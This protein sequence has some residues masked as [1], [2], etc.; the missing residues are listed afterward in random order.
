MLLKTILNKMEKY[1]SFVY[2]GV[3]FEV[4]EG[5]EALVVDVRS[6][7]NAKPE[8]PVCGWRFGRYDTQP[9]R[10][11]EYVPLWGFKVFFRYR[12]R[13]ANCPVH[14]VKVEHAP[15][16]QGKEHQTTSYKI[17]LAGWAKRLSWLEVA[18]IFDASWNTV[19]RAVKY[20]VDYGLAHRQL[21]NVETI[22][23][24]ELHVFHGQNY[25]TLV[26]QLDEGMKRLLWCAP[27]RK[28]STLLKFFEDLGAELSQKIKFVC[29]DM[30]AAYLT[31]I[32]EKAPQALNI[33]DRFH[34]MKK[35]NEAIDQI[36]R[37]EVKKLEEA[38]QPNVLVKSRWLLLKRPAKLGEKQTARLGE[39]LKIN[40]ATVKAYLMREDFQRFWEYK[41]AKEAEKFLDDWI[42]RTL[43]TKLEPMRQVA[44]ML[45]KHKP[46]I[47]N[48]FEAEGK[49]SSGAVE[50]MNLKANLTIRKSFGFRTTDCLKIALYHTLGKLPEPILAHRFL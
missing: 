46:L 43:K 33:L 29:S 5:Q 12:P 17:F 34:I 20:M 44:R 39:I 28:I 7:A 35:F 24:D 6:R 32:K 30:W 48:W 11:Y 3:R 23:V 4:V 47:L 50:G 19:Y 37:E 13:R 16:A 31:V 2:A 15:W 10:L 27:E 38:G 41:D 21:D 18:R 49:L 9:A 40:L 22:G 36:R 45:R 8:C 1:K 25:F 14:G 42:T 26:Y